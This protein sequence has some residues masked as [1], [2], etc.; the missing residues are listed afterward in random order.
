[1]RSTAHLACFALGLV[2]LPACE[3]SSPS[4]KPPTT[5]SRTGGEASPS[6][7]ESPTSDIVS[8]CPDAADVTSDPSARIGGS[9]H[10]DVDGD[11]SPDEV[12]LAFDEKA[13][14]GCQAFLIVEGADETRVLAIEGF[15]PGFGLPQPRLNTLAEVDAAPGSEVVVDLVTGASTQF[16]GLFTAT[17]EGL[18]RV[19]VEGDDFPT[20]DL[21]PYG[22]SVGHLEASNCAGEAGTVV[23]STATPRGADYQVTRRFFSFEDSTPRIE[24]SSTE[25]ERIAFEELRR[26]PEYKS[27]P[28][29]AC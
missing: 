26:F 18:A 8:E 22:G 9:L 7:T 17:G 15:D 24:P 4:V 27:A 13:A 19:V 6:P 3:G 12:S 28:F 11:G 20:D 10:G 1:M 16:V 21:F 23:V 14:R 29:G 5:I 25:R 2:F